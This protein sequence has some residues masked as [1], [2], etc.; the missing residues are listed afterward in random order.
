MKNNMPKGV[1]K[2]TIEHKETLSKS[3][4]GNVCS[5]KTKIK[6]SKANKGKIRS[7]E[8]KR[9]IGLSKTGVI[10]SLET[11]N[12]MSLAHKGEKSHLWKGGI[13]EERDKIRKNIE[14]RL[15]REAVFARDNW[16][17]QKTGDKGVVLNAHHIQNFADNPGLR[18][19]IENGVTL[20]EKAH[21]EFHRKYG[22]KNTTVEQLREFLSI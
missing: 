20:S 7:E 17:C 10:H 8:T 22:R 3:H 19:S 1:Y 4:T 18:T 15:W 2:R 14:I 5:A 6:I 21:K 9:K 13:T 16:T 12:K 11:R